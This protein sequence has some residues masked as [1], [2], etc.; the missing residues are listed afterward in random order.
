MVEADDAADHCRRRP[1]SAV[2][3][4]LVPVT[5][6]LPGH[7]EQRGG[8]RPEL[9]DQPVSLAVGDERQA[10]GAEQARSRPV[11]VEPTLAGRHDVKHHATREGGKDEAPGRRELRPT[12]EHAGHAQEMQRFAERVDRTRRNRWA[13]WLCHVR[14]YARLAIDRPPTWTNEHT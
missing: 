7:V 2:T 5:E 8:G 4:E 3:E 11:D 9:A 14:K 6:E 13:G 12:V 1:A 10:P